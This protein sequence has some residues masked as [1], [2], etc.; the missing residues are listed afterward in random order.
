MPLVAII[1]AGLGELGGAAAAATAAGAAGTAAGMGAGLGALGAGA[2]G[3]GALGALEAGI[4]MGSLMAGFNPLAYLASSGLGGALPA[5][6]GDLALSSA[7]PVAA[8]SIA[9]QAATTQSIQEALARQAAEQTAKQASLGFQGYNPEQLLA[10]NT[11][12]IAPNVITK[13]APNLVGREQVLNMF[14]EELGGSTPTFQGVPQGSPEAWS[15]WA[16]SDAAKVATAGDAEAYANAATRMAEANSPLAQQPP[17]QT[18]IVKGENALSNFINFMKSPSLKGAEDYVKEHPYATGMGA[19]ALYNA[20]QKKP[21]P[22]KPVSLIRPY[23]FQ[24]QQNPAAYAPTASTA[25][26]NYFNN[27]MVARTPYLAP[28]P[29]YAKAAGGIVALGVGGPVETMS[30]MNAVGDNQ[31]YPQSQL[32]TSDYSN[33][34]VQRPVASNVIKSAVDVNVDPYTGEQKMAGGGLSDLGGYSDGGRL[35]KG[36][37]DGVSDSIPAVIGDRQPAR[38]ADGEF[39]VPARIVSELGNG[40][41]EAGAKKLYAM[42]DR[43]Q[44]ARSKSVGK[45]RVAVDSKADKHLPA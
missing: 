34:M 16:T 7:V 6:A 18:P 23:D 30:A 28:G 43:V 9:T 33:P 38:L 25:E 29:E 31:M 1:T 10:A 12:A 44:R 19:Y 26:R 35:L 13:A 41:T 42:M 22:Q 36:P 32:Q 37:G 5:A 40:S 39:V 11:K 45:D 4:G 27:Q 21:E 8:E 15:K 3:A 2:A 14:K 20:L 17:L 24:S